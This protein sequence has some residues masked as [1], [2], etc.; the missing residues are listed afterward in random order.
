[1]DVSPRHAALAED[2]HDGF[3]RN[4][5]KMERQQQTGS[6]LGGS[7]AA[8]N[9]SVRFWLRFD[10]GM[11]TRVFGLWVA[12]FLSVAA[13]GQGTFLFNTFIPGS[14]DA[15]WSDWTGAGLGAGWTKSDG[16]WGDW[17]AQMFL[18]TAQGLILRIRRWCRRRH[19]EHPVLRPRTMLYH[20]R[21]RWLCLDYRRELRRL[22]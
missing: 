4:R 8:L 19:F 21:H 22:W 5:E 20:R 2:L 17:T 13:F 7:S 10:S 14:V 11:R 12:A 1:M 18:V 15:R 3:L 6:F 9:V 16:R